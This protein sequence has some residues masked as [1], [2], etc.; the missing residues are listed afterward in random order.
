MRKN[1]ADRL[2]ALES[3]Q[4]SM[5][6]TVADAAQSERGAK[7]VAELIADLNAEQA[8]YAALDAAGRI[9][10]WQN[11]IVA[12]QQYIKDYSDHSPPMRSGG[13]RTPFME[14]MHQSF[15]QSDLQD[16]RDDVRGGECWFELT[17]A[18][19]DRLAEL[20][21]DQSKLDTWN[22]VRRRYE[23]LPW[24]WRPEYLELPDD[25]LRFLSAKS[26]VSKARGRVH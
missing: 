15:W 21:Y 18:R 11:H 3:A 24:Q 1:L 13:Q 14:S 2:E 6:S 12:A 5:S 16:A 7:A 17:A 19:L 20:R 26:G 4:Q 22:V 23:K 10:H 9:R 25:A 8:V